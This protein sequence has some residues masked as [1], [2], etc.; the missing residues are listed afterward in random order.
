MVRRVV[1]TVALVS[2]LVAAPLVVAAPASAIP[3]CRAGY[4]CDRMYYTDV[5]HEVIVGGF[6][7]FCDGSTISWGETTIYQVTTQAR[8]Q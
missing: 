3:A 5:T 7:L 8:C 6:T 1:S 2:A 4:Q